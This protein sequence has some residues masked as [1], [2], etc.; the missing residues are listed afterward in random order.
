MRGAIA[1]ALMTLASGCASP[2]QRI[3]AKLTEYGV[4]EAR[5]RC[6]GDRLEQRLSV[7]QLRRLGGLAALNRDRMGRMTVNDIVRMLDR[8]GDEAIV[9]EVLRAGLGC[10]I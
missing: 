5:A 4:P 8:P 10:L 3:S 2:A 9:A 1:I 7:A 6:M